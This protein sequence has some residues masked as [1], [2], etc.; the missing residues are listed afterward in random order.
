MMIIEIMIVII[1]MIENND[2]QPF[3]LFTGKRGTVLGVVLTGGADEQ[4]CSYSHAHLPL[5]PVSSSS[6]QDPICV[7]DRSLVCEFCTC[8]VS[9]TRHLL[10]VPPFGSSLP[11]LIITVRYFPS[12][13]IVCFIYFPFSFPLSVRMYVVLCSLVL[14]VLMW[15]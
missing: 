15:C 12:S 14:F 8:L 3:S 1:I 2:N 7:S 6:L 11:F 13:Y 4:V 5:P 9:A 10:A